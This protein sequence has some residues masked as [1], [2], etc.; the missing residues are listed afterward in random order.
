MGSIGK[1]LFTITIGRLVQFVALISWR[2]FHQMVL[3]RGVLIHI[4]QGYL[5][6]SGALLVVMSPNYATWVHS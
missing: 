2:L 6:L 3:K 1:L 4:V 5:R